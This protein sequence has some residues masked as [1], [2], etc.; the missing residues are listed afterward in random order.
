MRLKGIHK[1]CV[2]HRF[3]SGN[4]SVY[5]SPSRQR[6]MADLPQ[7]SPMSLHIN[8]GRHDPQQD[9]PKVLPGKPSRLLEH[10]ASRL[11]ERTIRQSEIITVV[12]SSCLQAAQ[13]VADCS[14]A[15]RISL[16]RDLIL[17][18]AELMLSPR[19]GSPFRHR[20]PRSGKQVQ[21]AT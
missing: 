14:I 13:C 21:L 11:A 7:G 16:F 6:Y 8:S 20:R 9:C 10:D 1:S 17:R 3:S 15:S 4:F 12:L 18:S 5:R 2:A 19:N